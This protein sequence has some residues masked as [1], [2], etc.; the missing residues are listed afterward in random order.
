MEIY[1]IDFMDG[2]LTDLLG[3]RQSHRNETYVLLHR[4]KPQAIRVAQQ[5]D[6]TEARWLLTTFERLP[7][8]ELGALEFCPSRTY[9]EDDYAPPTFLSRALVGQ[10]QQL[11]YVGCDPWFVPPNS[12]DD[13]AKAL[14]LI[15][16]LIAMDPVDSLALHCLLEAARSVP[17]G[18]IQNDNWWHPDVLLQIIDNPE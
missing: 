4:L 13:S 5:L 16:K 8:S 1:D 12:A 7:Q 6:E 11:V 15:D 17:Q 10:F 14:T 18:I 2:I 9:E 3:I